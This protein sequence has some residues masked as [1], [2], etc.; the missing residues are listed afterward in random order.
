MTTVTP[1]A[2]DALVPIDSIQ[3]IDRHRN[4]LGDIEALAKSIADVGLLNPITLTRDGR[5]VAGQRRLAACRHLGW[6]EVPARLVDSLQDVAWLLRAERDENTCRKDMLPSELASLGAALEEMESA[7]ALGR[8]RNG[9]E[10]GRATRYSLDQGTGTPIQDSSKTGKVTAAVGEALGMAGRTYQELAYVHRIANGQDASEDERNLA[11]H[12]LAEM[13]RRGMIAPPARRLRGCLRAKHD[14]QRARA[15][16]D[17]EPVQED[18]ADDDLWVPALR[19][20]RPSSAAQ[21]VNLIRHHAPRGYTAAQIG[22]RIGGLN[23]ERVRQIAREHGIDLPGEQV[24]RGIKRINSNRVVRETVHAL[25]GLAMGVQLVKI[26]DLD[27]A[28]THGWANSMT[29]SIRTLNRLIKSLKE[30]S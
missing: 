10:R 14:A 28:E 7:G 20:S 21:R 5:L 13:D 25:E 8:R 4:N 16:A 19:D 18:P 11:R 17:P 26:A 23:A 24:M 22:D 12:T 3:L 9:Q 2:I 27:P 29:D 1:S 15:A 6:D 30:A